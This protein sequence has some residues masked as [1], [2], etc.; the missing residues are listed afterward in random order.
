MRYTPPR[1][2]IE[3]MIDDSTKY[4]DDYIEAFIRWVNVNIWGPL[5]EVE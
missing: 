5:G 2:V 4:G 1:N 3:K